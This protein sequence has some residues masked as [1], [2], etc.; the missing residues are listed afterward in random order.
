MSQY[1][2]NNTAQTKHSK[3]WSCLP[4]LSLGGHKCQAQNYQ[5]TLGAMEVRRT[6]FYHLEGLKTNFRLAQDKDT[7][8]LRFFFKKMN[9]DKAY[10]KKTFQ[11]ILSKCSKHLYS[12][13]HSRNQFE[14]LKCALTSN[15]SL[16]GRTLSNSTGSASPFFHLFSFHVYASLN[17]SYCFSLP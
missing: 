6:K 2:Q 1:M 9:F 13:R 17:A 7:T 10:K 11:V 14:L 3:F 8:Y 5:K 16:V 4:L 12:P 15:L